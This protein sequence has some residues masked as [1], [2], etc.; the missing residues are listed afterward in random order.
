MGKIE[1]LRILIFIF[2]IS[3]SILHI[4]GNFTEKKLKKWTKKQI[5]IVSKN[6]GTQCD[7]W[8]IETLKTWDVYPKLEKLRIFLFFSLVIS[9]I[10]SIISTILLGFTQI[11]C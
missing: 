4:I 2:V 7:F 6:K 3:V 9:G 10:M 1:V 11:F 8:G 5:K